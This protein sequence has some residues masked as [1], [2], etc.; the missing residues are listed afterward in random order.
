MV[1]QIEDIKSEQFA[2]TVKG[3][4]QQSCDVKSFSTS[5]LCKLRS[6]GGFAAVFW[7]CPQNEPVLRCYHWLLSWL[8]T[9]RHINKEGI[10]TFDDCSVNINFF[11]KGFVEAAPQTSLSV[12]RVVPSITQRSTGGA[13]CRNR[14]FCIFR[15]GPCGNFLEC[16]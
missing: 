13:R 11:R 4:C 9:A 7:A 14:L 12:P 6:A 16:T 8:C 1:V 15:S 2:V 10:K 3:R 5:D